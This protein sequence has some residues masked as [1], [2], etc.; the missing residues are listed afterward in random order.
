MKPAQPSAGAAVPAGLSWGAQLVP[1]MPRGE[2][3]PHGCVGS[4]PTP[5]TMK[6]NHLRGIASSFSPIVPL[7]GV[8]I[9]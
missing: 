7:I 5:G 8:T 9:V 4:I 3:N 6:I 1:G 2:G